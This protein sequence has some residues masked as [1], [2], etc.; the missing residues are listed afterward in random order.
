MSWIYCLIALISNF[1][2][3]YCYL[4][5]FL[6]LRQCLFANNVI[7]TKK[8]PGWEIW[9][10]KSGRKEKLKFYRLLMLENNFII[11][12]KEKWFTHS[13]LWKNQKNI[14]RSEWKKL[15]NNVKTMLEKKKLISPEWFAGFWKFFQNQE[16]KKIIQKI[17]DDDNTRDLPWEKISYFFL[18]HKNYK[19]NSKFLLE[20]NL[21]QIKNKNSWSIPI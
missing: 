2:R 10:Q 13:E 15:R 7:F 8:I 4:S 19:K 1:L 17:E 6:L 11:V 14:Q 9:I 20:E 3:C 16:W 21:T 12:H 5:N 18:L